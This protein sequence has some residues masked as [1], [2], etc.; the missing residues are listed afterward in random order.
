MGP[1]PFFERK[2]LETRLCKTRPAPFQGFRRIITKT[3]AILI[4]LFRSSF[5]S[6]WLLNFASSITS[7]DNFA[8]TCVEWQ[9]CRAHLAAKPQKRALFRERVAEPPPPQSPRSFTAPPVLFG[10]PTKTAML[11]MLR[12]PISLKKPTIWGKTRDENDVRR[13][14]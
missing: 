10:R 2:A 1:H 4:F 12:R 5:S 8:V 11:R 7:Q 13:Y 14:P 9:F 3:I 6:S